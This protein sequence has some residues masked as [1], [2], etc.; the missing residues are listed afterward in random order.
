MN[1]FKSWFIDNRNGVILSIITCFLYV[2]PI[3]LVGHIYID[4]HTRTTRLFLWSQ[5]AR[6]AV[7]FIFDTL[8][9]GSGQL[10]YFPFTN[11]FGAILIGMSGV[12]LCFIFNI[13]GT[14]GIL[15]I[16]TAIISS[17]FLV[18]NLTYRFDSITMGLSILTA[19]TPYIYVNRPKVFSLLS[20]ILL[21]ITA[22]L[23]QPSMAIYVSIGIAY[24]SVNYR[25]FKRFSKNIIL[26]CAL[27]LVSSISIIIISRY[28]G[29]IE[30]TELFLSSNDP[31][32]ALIKNTNG[33]LSLIKSSAHGITLYSYFLAIVCFAAGCA[34]SL[35]KGVSY[36]L[37]QIT[38]LILVFI[39][40]IILNVVLLAPWF[41]SRTMIAFPL[42]ISFCFLV[43][44]KNIN[45]KR[46]AALPIVAVMLTSTL[47][48]TSVFANSLSAQDRINKIYLSKILSVT[49][50][51]TTKIAIYGKQPLSRELVRASSVYPL[52][53]NLVPNYMIQGSGWAQAY[54]G[55]MT[56]KFQMISMNEQNS[57]ISESCSVKKWE[58]GHMF[59]Y[60]NYKEYLI[61]SFNGNNCR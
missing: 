15:L 9:L 31:L 14:T 8:S 27:F 22:M 50:E 34:A 30:R 13:S 33:M 16:A 46:T 4:D 52:L 60:K 29:E 48:F 44:I 24:H 51:E 1:N 17:P 45:V 54:I 43:F 12:A 61:I 25:T 49:N 37:I 26:M 5:D 6:Y 10:D 47:L 36:A 35:K 38:S 21:I 57:I 18:S 39:S 42:L 11:I 59:F 55:M 40:T 19:T 58:R 32:G 20:V 3:I 28:C 53:E 56:S 41:N 2:L 23:Y 7:N